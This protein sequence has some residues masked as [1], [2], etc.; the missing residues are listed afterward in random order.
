[1]LD[2]TLYQK[3]L[4]VIEELEKTVVKKL[5]LDIDVEDFWQY[6]SEIAEKRRAKFD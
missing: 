6:I 4:D 5:E 3:A 1:M 2:P